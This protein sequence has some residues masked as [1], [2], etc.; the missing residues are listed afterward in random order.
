M[1][2]MMLAVFRVHFVFYVHISLHKDPL[3]VRNKFWRCRAS[4]FVFRAHVPHKV[5]DPAGP[6]PGAVQVQAA[7]RIVK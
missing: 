1:P 7:E 5:M 4:C 6:S 3:W 2:R